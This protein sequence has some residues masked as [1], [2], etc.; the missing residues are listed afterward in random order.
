MEVF[1][2]KNE[3]WVAIAWNG[4][5]IR[6]VSSRRTSHG[7]SHTLIGGYVLDDDMQA[8]QKEVEVLGVLL[9]LNGHK[10]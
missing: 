9:I 5:A 3:I 4:F 1:I 10:Q 7:L 8:L 2:S 6:G